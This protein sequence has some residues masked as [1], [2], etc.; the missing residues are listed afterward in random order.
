MR[1]QLQAATSFN[2]KSKELFG[3]YLSHRIKTSENDE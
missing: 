2:E 3:G 1:K